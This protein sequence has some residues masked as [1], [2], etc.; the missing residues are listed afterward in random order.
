MYL[1]T[2]FFSAGQHWQS[3]L[4]LISLSLSLLLDLVGHSMWN[5][6]VRIYDLFIY[7]FSIIEIDACDLLHYDLDSLILP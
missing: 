5:L 1:Q 7:L 6:F 2:F 4:A 3:I